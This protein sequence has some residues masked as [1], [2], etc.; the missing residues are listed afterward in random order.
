MGLFSSLSPSASVIWAKME[1][2]SKSWKCNMHAA[3]TSLDVPRAPTH[4]A[5]RR[6][7][8]GMIINLCTF[9]FK[10]QQGKT[11]LKCVYA[12]FR[13]TGSIP[14]PHSSIMCHGHNECMV[15]NVSKS[16][17]CSIGTKVWKCIPLARLLSIYGNVKSK[18]DVCNPLPRGIEMTF[19]WLKSRYLTIHATDFTLTRSMYCIASL[20]LL[21]S[22]V[23]HVTHEALLIEFSCKIYREG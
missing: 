1:K 3:E 6:E 9:C 13:G 17:N 8:Q 23:R 19:R 11:F 14:R 7:S 18:I 5:V 20:P 22:L 16:L 12:T 15:R 4:T 2:S 21:L 10:S